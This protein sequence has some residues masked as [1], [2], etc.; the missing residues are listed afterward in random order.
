MHSSSSEEGDGQTNGAYMCQWPSTSDVGILA[1]GVISETR[2]GWKDSHAPR[3]TC[4]CEA[5]PNMKYSANSVCVQEHTANLL[6]WLAPD[7]AYPIIL[8]KR[9]AI[10]TRNPSQLGERVLKDGHPLL[11][12][13]NKDWSRWIVWGRQTTW[14]RGRSLRSWEPT[15]HLPRSWWLTNP[16]PTSSHGTL[17]L[18]RNS[19]W[20]PGLTR[21]LI[22]LP[23]EWQTAGIPTTQ[24]WPGFEL[25]SK[26]VYCIERDK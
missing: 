16:A 21:S 7:L 13:G 24:Q 12:V 14:L 9:L 8:G 4:R 5:L 6:T 26:W 17:T 22:S 20:I 19:W 18:Y 2:W 11:A 23:H 1:T 10:F 25:Q 15:T 3:Y